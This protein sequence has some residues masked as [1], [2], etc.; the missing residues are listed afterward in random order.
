MVQP[1][2]VSCTAFR[3]STRVATGTLEQVAQEV[4]QLIDRGEQ[5]SILIFD[6]AN[7]EVL[8]IDFRGTLAE[9]LDRLPKA[10][11][12]PPPR[13]GPGRPKLGV[14]GREVTLL[15]RHWDWLS[16]QPGGASVALRKLVEAAKKANAGADRVRSSRESAYRFMSA[17][18]GD[19]PGFE[20]ATRAL[21]AGN[22]PGFRAQ[23]ASWPSDLRDHATRLAEPA[24]QGES[25]KTTKGRD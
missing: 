24:L 18:A 13:Q 7:S 23:T 1:R 21:F 16:R 17:M 19:L 10:P 12:E 5:A 6:D 3:G 15:P 14:V 2:P 8:E 4:K 20:E 22:E 9:V 11:D 25:A